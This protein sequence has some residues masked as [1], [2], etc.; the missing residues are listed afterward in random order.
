[1]T[2]ERIRP[3]D[4]SRM[5]SLSVRQ[6]QFLAAGGKIPGAAKLGGVWTFDPVQIKAWITAEECRTCHRADTSISGAT[7]GGAASVS[8][9]ESIDEAFERLIRKR[10]RT[11]F[12]AGAS[13]LKGPLS[14]RQTA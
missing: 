10:P 5:T 4:V 7:H 3:A 12:A 9:A 11:V 2:A 14:E 8:M 13:P 1:M 6:V